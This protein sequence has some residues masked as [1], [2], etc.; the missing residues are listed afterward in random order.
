MVYFLLILNI[1]ML[2]S[3][4][5]LWKMAVSNIEQWSISTFISL[6]ISPYFLGGAILYIMATG[7][8]LI[9]L[10]KLPLSIAYPS[11]SISYVLGTIIAF[12]LFKETILP[13]QWIGM[14]VIILGVFLIAK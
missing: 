14:L 10:S 3:G 13:T 1:L 7:I 9:I 8:W 5:V 4:Q 11:Q 12:V 6:A 2:V